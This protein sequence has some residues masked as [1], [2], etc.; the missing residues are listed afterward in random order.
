M[1]D[2]KATFLNPEDA[3][4]GVTALNDTDADTSSGGQG[5]NRPNA[6]VGVS[7]DDYDPKESDW[8]RDDRAGYQGQSCGDRQ[9]F[10]V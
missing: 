1:P 2:Q 9:C 6:A 3:Q 8:S 5:M 10:R 4:A 7:T